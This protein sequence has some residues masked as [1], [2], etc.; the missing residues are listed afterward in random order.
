MQ[1]THKGYLQQNDNMVDWVCSM[2]EEEAAEIKYQLSDKSKEVDLVSFES[3]DKACRPM[4]DYNEK[5]LYG[6]SW[7]DF[8]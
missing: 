5:L 4:K 3:S 8:S 6:K 2:N 1:K 7:T